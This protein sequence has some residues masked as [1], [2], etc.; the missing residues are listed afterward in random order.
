MANV[1]IRQ[2]FA[3]CGMTNGPV[4]MV[5]GQPAV[6][7]AAQF[8]ASSG[9]DDPEQLLNFE[10]GD[11]TEMIKAHH[12]RGPQIYPVSM[13]V[14]KN[15]QALIYFAKYRWRRGLPIQIAHWDADAMARIKVIMQQAAARKA[16]KTAEN[17]DP[18]PIEVGVGYRD[19]VGRFRNKLKSTIGA[20]DVPLIYVIR[21]PHDDDADWVPPEAETDIYAMRLDG[22]EF[23]QDN[24]AV[25]TLLY[26]CCNHEKAAGRTEAMAWIDPFFVAQDGRAA[27]AAFRNHFE[28]V[29]AMNIRRTS[30]L[31]QIQQL[32]WK[33]ELLVTFAEFSSKLKKA[34]DVLSEEAPYSDLFKVRELVGKMN[35]MSKQGSIDSVK[36]TIMREYSNDFVGAIDY[37]LN[38]ITDIYRDEIE[39][40]NRVGT[41]GKRQVSEAHIEQRGGRGGRMR[42]DNRGGRA[43]HRQGNRNGG[44]RR[45]GGSGRWNAG[46][47][48]TQGGA[49]FNGVDCSDPTR[50]FSAAEWERIGQ[51]GRGFVNRERQCINGRGRGG[52]GNYGGG[53]QARGRGRMINEVIIPVG[54]TGNETT[55][56]E[57]MTVATRGGRSGA[58]FGRGA[59]TNRD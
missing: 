26:N 32:H 4:V 5:P 8:V 33:S 56:G 14:A 27:F 37:A 50:D 17:I 12:R 38:R 20:A 59:H 9:I 52:R 54:G 6:N 22:P 43:G 49:N 51:A 30:A 29:G 46:G 7:P 1:P 57:S 31:A 15:L 11:V 2:M 16:D 41:G 36:E 42:Y 53:Y 35:P 13:V 23:D 34:Y 28:G 44:G 39:R 55:A 19:W 21:V 48:G 18:G 40:K 47:G 10:P 25:Y 3:V 24:K 45:G 58:G